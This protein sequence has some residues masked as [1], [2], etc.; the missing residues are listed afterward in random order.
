MKIDLAM[1]RSAGRAVLPRGIRD[2]LRG[3]YFSAADRVWQTVAIHGGAARRCVTN[4]PYLAG[5][6]RPRIFCDR[7]SAD[8]FAEA[9]A[10]TGAIP[11]VVWV[12]WHEAE[13]PTVINNAIDV[14][15][16]VDPTVEVRVLSK[17]TVHQWLPDFVVPDERCSIQ[18]MTDLLRLELLWAYGGVWID[19]GTFFSSP[20]DV[21]FPGLW[22]EDGAW[23]DLMGFSLDRF[24]TN[25]DRPIVENWFLAAH[26][27]NTLVGEW[28][29]AL[30]P[31]R[32]GGAAALDEELRAE[33]GYSSY[34]QKLV[35][36]EYLV[37][38]IALQRVLASRPYRLYLQSAD[39]SA[40]AVHMSNSLNEYRI[41][42]AIFGLPWEGPLPA[43]VK[44]RGSE[45]RQFEIFDAQ[46]SIHPCSLYSRMLALTKPS[47][48]YD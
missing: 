36:P 19:A 15:R 47:G 21:L 46:S 27:G 25:P 17:N 8:S 32:D 2:L 12:Y 30:S 34:R 9:D 10:R 11:R 39:Q 18:H 4:R 28:L 1:V 31:M 42:I 24:T 33:S 3:V 20:L 13:R 26:R 5:D 22:G 40:L 35:M 7:A 14:L 41:G 45:R 29:N 38:H 37:S 44:F 23:V 6:Y 16:Y 43:V 48:G